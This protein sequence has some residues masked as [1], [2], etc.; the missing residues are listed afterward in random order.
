MKIAIFVGWEYDT[1]EDN[2][3]LVE[4]IRFVLIPKL[5]WFFT[6]VCNHTTNMELLFYNSYARS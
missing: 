5:L 6:R 2:D 1:M 4:Y 3:V